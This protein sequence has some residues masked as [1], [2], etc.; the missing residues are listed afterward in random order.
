MGL[1][2]HRPASLGPILH[3]I[4]KILARKQIVQLLYITT[5]IRMENK[6]MKIVTDTYTHARIHT[7]TS[8]HT[9]KCT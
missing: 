5:P 4:K 7:Q 2:E 9:S 3:L 6:L 1:S 8:R